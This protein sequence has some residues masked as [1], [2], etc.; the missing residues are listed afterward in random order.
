MIAAEKWA[1]VTGG[2]SG[3][4]LAIAEQ[5]AAKKY[6]LLLVSNQEAALKEVQQRLMKTYDI[7]ID[8]LFLDLTESAAAKEMYDY[9]EAKHYTVEVLINNAGILLFSE[10]VDTIP[11][12]VS[13][14]VQLHM[15]TPTLLC[16]YFGEKMKE[17]KRGFILNISSMSAVMPY[18]GISLYGPTKTYLRYFSRALRS[19]LKPY[20]VNVCCALP[21]ATATGLYDPNK[22]NLKLAMRLGVMKS[23]P[24]VAHVLTKALFANRAESIPGL[25]NKIVVLFFPLI[26]HAMII[27]INKYIYQRGKGRST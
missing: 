11:E 24:S 26:P 4:G 21:G 2:S 27:Q 13:G 3:I 19:E 23:A 25:L 22:V 14:I 8:T 5:L 15:H 18:P 20:G 12:K 17:R 10:V 1:L 16:R 9:C 6:H 7:Q